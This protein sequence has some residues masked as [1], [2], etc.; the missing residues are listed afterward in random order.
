MHN[1][2]FKDIDIYF[3]ADRPK[4]RFSL[5]YLTSRGDLHMENFSFT[6]I[7][8]HPTNMI[9]VNFFSDCRIIGMEVLNSKF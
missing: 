7:G 9:L 6:N 1:N 3:T 4:Q 2:V 8:G 5:I